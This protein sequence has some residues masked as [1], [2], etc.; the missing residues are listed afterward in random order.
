[1]GT[2]YAIEWSFLQRL[3]RGIRSSVGILALPFRPLYNNM[4]RLSSF[5]RDSHFKCSRMPVLLPVSKFTYIVGDQLLEDILLD[6]E[7]LNIE[8]VWEIID[9]YKDSILKV[10]DMDIKQEAMSLSRIGKV[11]DKVLKIKFRAREY[12]KKALEL[13]QSITPFDVSNEGTY[14]IFLVHVTCIYTSWY[15][16]WCKYKK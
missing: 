4:S 9:W 1:M 3:T 11:Y 13:A 14:P 12:L 10:R 6:E 8:M 16:W 15:T 7:T 2:W 5:V